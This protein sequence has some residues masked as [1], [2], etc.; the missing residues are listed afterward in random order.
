MCSQVS[1]EQCVR[2]RFADGPEVCDGIDDVSGV[3]V[4]DRSDDEVQS[5][6]PELL[7]L[8]TAFSNTTLLECADHLRERLTLRIVVKPRL[9]PLS[10]GG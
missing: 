9:A 1:G 3:A 5:R 7:R 10:Q 2:H 4:H 6:G 8:L